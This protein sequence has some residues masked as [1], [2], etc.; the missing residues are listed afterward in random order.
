[1]QMRLI[2]IFTLSFGTGYAG[3]GYY[4][5]PHNSA[6][7]DE[8]PDVRHY[9]SREAAPREYH[10]QSDY[11]G[12]TTRACRATRTGQTGVSRWAVGSEML[13]RVGFHPI[14]MEHFKC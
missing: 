2:Q 11:A 13:A 9:A 14:G 12:Y 5:G 1:M 3:R 10:R 7:Y 4:D 8:R 6:N